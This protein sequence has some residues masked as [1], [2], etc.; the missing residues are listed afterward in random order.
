MKQERLHDVRLLASEPFLQPPASWH[1]LPRRACVEC[2]DGDA[3]LFKLGDQRSAGG[4]GS[5]AANGWFKAVA[6]Q[7]A[8][9]PDECL[10]GT[11]DAESGDN[12]TDSPPIVRS[13]SPGGHEPSFFSF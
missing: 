8:R 4:Q 6:G 1:E 11:A 5:D 9:E 7:S 12:Q 10:F 2:V 13:R 3:G